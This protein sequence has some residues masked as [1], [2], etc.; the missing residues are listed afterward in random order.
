[1]ATVGVKGLMNASRRLHVRIYF[2]IFFATL[3]CEVGASRLRGGAED[4]TLSRCELAMRRRTAFLPTDR[5]TYWRRTWRNYGIN[6][7]R[8]DKTT[9]RDGG[10]HAMAADWKSIRRLDWLVVPHDRWRRNQRRQTSQD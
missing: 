3:F 6:L 1:M 2:F 7:C 5:P 8:W 4:K 10:V 9:R